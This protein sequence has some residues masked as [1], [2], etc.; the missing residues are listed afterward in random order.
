MHL[1]NMHQLTNLSCCRYSKI[2]IIQTPNQ[3][4]QFYQLLLSIINSELET[5]DVN[6]YVHDLGRD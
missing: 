4:L 1:T 5:T 2:Y 6:C 3:S